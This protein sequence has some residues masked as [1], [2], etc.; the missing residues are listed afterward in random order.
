MSNDHVAA[1]DLTVRTTG[2]HETPRV[3]TPVTLSVRPHRLDGGDTLDGTSMPTS[4]PLID[5]YGRIHRDLRISIT[6]RC[7][8]RCVYCMSEDMVFQPREELLTF[9]ELVRVARVA[10][11]LGVTSMR[12]TGG[13]PLVRRGVVDLVARLGELGVEDLA[14]TTNATRL[15]PLAVPLKAAGLTRVNISCDSL[16]VDRFASIRR[17]G[18]LTTVLRAMDEAESAGLAPLKVNVVL[19]R[20]INDDEI[21]DFAR[22]AR[23]TGRIV[24]FIEFMPL[25][26]PGQWDRD[27]LVAGRDV[28][29]TVNAVWPLE[30]VDEPGR[31]APAERFRFVD[32]VGEIGLISTVTQPFCG[33]CD[34]LR[35][36]SDGSIRNCLFSDDEHALRD[37]LRTGCDDDAIQLVL[38]RAVWNK[39]PGHAINETDFLRP[40]RSMSM[41]GG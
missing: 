34:R 9:D 25:D 36:T 18:D 20:G 27:R 6:D 23:T 12:L 30:P 5:R 2:D 22:F 37:L 15:A 38:R 16:R 35:L 4:G 7:N 40:H 1:H 28:W 24:R 3:T 14:L 17:R 10:R 31:V 33:T 29:A 39:F 13:E 26:A 32:G 11:D 41:I 19:L 21:L 8:L